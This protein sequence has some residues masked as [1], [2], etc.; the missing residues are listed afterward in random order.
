MVRGRCLCGD[1]AFEVSADIGMVTHCHCSMCRK[2]HGSAF[3]THGAVTARRLSV[4]EGPGAGAALR[5]LAR[6]RATVLPPLRVERAVG[7][8]AG[9]RL[10]SARQPRRRSARAAARPH[11][12]RIEGALVRHRRR[13]AALRRV[14]A[15]LRRRGAARSG[16]GARAGGRVRGS[17]LCG[18]VAY[19]V[20]GAI[21][22]I[23]HCH[24]GVAGARAA[25]RTRPMASSTPARFRFLHGEELLDSF[26]VPD[27]ERFTQTSVA[28]AARRCRASSRIAHTSW[29]HGQPTASPGAARASTSSSARRRPGTRSPIL[30]PSTPSTRRHS[31]GLVRC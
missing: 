23:R 8:H 1:V 10:R 2:F 31:R 30:C 27:A 24:C 7:S 4:A 18:A 6:W 3:A 26:K 5:V 20:E 28:H 12:R 21:E 14:P 16:P 9:L 25:R 17:C 15:R 29:F 13:P 19:E 22:L 11:L